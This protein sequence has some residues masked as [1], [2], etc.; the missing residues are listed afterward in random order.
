MS[1]FPCHYATYAYEVKAMAQRRGEVAPPAK[2]KPFLYVSMHRAK[3]K[4][5][6]P[7]AQSRL[8]EKQVYISPSHTSAQ[9]L[10]TVECGND[11]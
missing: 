2:N 3:E 8:S 9:A 1:Q 6:R 10:R 5:P 7:M 4:R 11:Q